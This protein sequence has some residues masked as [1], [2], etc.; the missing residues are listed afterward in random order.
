MPALRGDEVYRKLRESFNEAIPSGRVIAQRAVARALAGHESDRNWIKS[1]FSRLVETV[2]VDAYKEYLEAE[3]RVGGKAL[4]D[5]F[6]R[7]APKGSSPEEVL[8]LVGHYFFSLDR[9]F[10]GL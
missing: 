7:L 5:V 4:K 9:F 3:S 6:L 10:L 2:Q 1:H 8:G